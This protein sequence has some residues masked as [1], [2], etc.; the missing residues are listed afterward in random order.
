MQVSVSY[1]GLNDEFAHRR[2]S[3][4]HGIPTSDI[5]YFKA[6]EYRCYLFC[7]CIGGFF[8]FFIRVSVT[9]IYGET[10]QAISEQ[11]MADHM[12]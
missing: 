8:F 5:V 7:L 12:K 3:N 11:Y 6:R 9:Q 4:S 2:K 1:G 10:K